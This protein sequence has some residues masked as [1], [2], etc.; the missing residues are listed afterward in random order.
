MSSIFKILIRYA[1]SQIQLLIFSLIYGIWN[2]FFDKQ[3]GHLR[4]RPP[5]A[6][7]TQIS[8]NF[9]A[10]IRTPDYLERKALSYKILV[11]QLPY[12]RL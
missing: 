7:H 6:L 4:Y 11:C 2:V 8:I 5:Q 1:K 3:E 12:L 9:L 10:L